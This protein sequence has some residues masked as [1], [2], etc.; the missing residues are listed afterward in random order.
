MR[1]PPRVSRHPSRSARSVLHRPRRP[2][3]VLLVLLVLAAPAARAGDLDL[4][5][6][7]AARARAV[8]VAVRPRAALLDAASGP[9]DAPALR[10]A[11]D[12]V[13]L[14]TQ[15]DEPSTAFVIGI[16]TKDARL[17]VLRVEEG[18]LV[19]SSTTLSSEIRLLPGFR[20]GEGPFPPDFDY[21]DSA[22]N[23]ERYGDAPAV[24]ERD[25]TLRC[26]SAPDSNGST[27]RCSNGYGLEV[28][29]SRCY[30]ALDGA[31]T[32]ERP[33]E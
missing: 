25:Y 16:R 19:W 12:G 4:V 33:T 13:A 2:W 10:Q 26:T 5:N 1:R 18:R 17:L 29:A 15:L 23:R 20:S 3:P 11:L 9:Q 24:D 28:F 30:R 21:T 32:C 7:V 6:E 8:V 27:L 22:Y 31:V 14:S